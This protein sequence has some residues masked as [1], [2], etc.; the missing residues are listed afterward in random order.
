[1]RWTK[2]SLLLGASMF[3]S[4][5]PAVA[6]VL[7]SGGLLGAQPAI[8]APCSV[9]QET[10]ETQT[11]SDGTHIVT[12][13]EIRFYRDSYGRTRT[14]SFFN[15]PG[16]SPKEPT[17]IQI[18]DPVAGTRYH[19]NVQQR[20]A[21]LIVPRKLPINP[22]VV[23]KPVPYPQERV[24]KTTSEDLGTQSIEGVLAEGVRTTMIFP[25]GSQG[26]DRPLQVVEETWVSKELGLTLLE[27]H[28]D[29]R[30]GESVT[31]VTS[32]DRSEPDPTLF[33]VPPDYAV[34][35]LLLKAP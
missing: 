7:T 27:K 3:L 34:L 11:L 32:L 29:P 31:R 1:M 23:Q 28:S 33:Q 24:P 16:M 2:A 21:V 20:V 4:A 12:R 13:S 14:D 15:H 9:V 25:V 10:E 18:Q 35:D 6:Q 30:H 17:D 26:N 5:I 22:N 19:L 8:N